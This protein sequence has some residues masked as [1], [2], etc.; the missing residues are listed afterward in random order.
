MCPTFLTFFENSVVC[1][2]F[3]FTTTFFRF[4]LSYFWRRHCQNMILQKLEIGS[5][6]EA[7]PDSKYNMKISSFSLEENQSHPETLAYP[8]HVR[9]QKEINH[10]SIIKSFIPVFYCKRMEDDE[11]AKNAEDS[12]SAKFE[13]LTSNYEWLHQ[14]SFVSNVCRVEFLAYDWSVQS[15]FFCRAHDLVLLNEGLNI[16]WRPEAV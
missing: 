3:F 1:V 12:K 15:F 5:R 8:V 10:W 16:R 9:L 13:I 7:L 6:T 2:R 14:F 11:R 4:S